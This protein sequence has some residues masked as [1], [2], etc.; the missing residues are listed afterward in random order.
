[1]MSF[2]TTILLFLALL[3]GGV[4]AARHFPAGLSSP[5]VRKEDAA[6]SVTQVAPVVRQ[7][8][9][10]ADPQ[11]LESLDVMCRGDVALRERLVE[12]VQTRHPGRGRVWAVGKAEFD[13]W[14]D[15][16]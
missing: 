16:R 14:R 11:E 5:G 12:G 15:N 9:E 7:A 10:V 3:F 6:P 13:Y 4:R 1:M 8:V 2:V